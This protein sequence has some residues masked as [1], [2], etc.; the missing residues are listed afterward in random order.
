MKKTILIVE[1][2][3]SIRAIS[4]RIL[5]QFGYLVLEARD[6]LAALKLLAEQSEKVDLLITDVIMPN[7]SGKAL[8]DQIK[9]QQ[10]DLKILIISGYTGRTLQEKGILTPDTPFLSKPFRPTELVQKVREVLSG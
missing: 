10:P 9:L 1:D 7:M 8:A 5:R 4:T 2:D 3:V 6:G